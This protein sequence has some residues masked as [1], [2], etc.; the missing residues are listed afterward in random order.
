[1]CFLQAIEA[2]VDLALVDRSGD[3]HRKL[4]ASEHAVVGAGP[5]AA[6]PVYREV[7][8]VV[9]PTDVELA[10]LRRV[11]APIPWKVYTIAFVE[12]VERMSFY[13]TTAVFNNFIQ[14]PN[15]GTRTGAAPNPNDPEAQPGALNLGQRVAQAITLTN[16]MMVYFFPLLGAWVADTYLGRFKTIVYAIIIAEIGHVLLT[17]SAAPGMLE[18]PPQALGLFIIGLVIM[19][20]GTG[21][22]KPN[23]SPLIAEQ[24]GQ[25]VM[26]VQVTKKGE[27]VIVDPNI[28][29]SR[30]FNWF[31]LFINVGSLVGSLGMSYA[32]R[33]VGFYLSFLIPT[34]MFLTTLP[35]LFFC[36]KYYTQRPPEGSV[37]GPAFKLLFLGMKKGFSPNPI[38][39]V[40]RWNNG[41]FWQNV[42]VTSKPAWM[43]FDDAWVDE[44]ARGWA[45]CSV[46]LFYPLYWLTYN[47]MNNNLGAQ[48]KTMMLHGVPNDVM[49]NLNPIA[50]IVFVPLMDLGFYPLL[51]RFGI[52]F[53]PIKKITVGFFFSV[54]AMIWAAVLQHYIYKMSPCGKQASAKCKA[55]I[56]VW[57]QTGI[58]VLVAISEIFAS[59]TSLEYAYTKAPKNMRSLVQAFSLM[60][61]AFSAALGFALLGLADNPFLVWNYAIPGFIAFAA[62]CV[63]W[64]MYRGLDKREDHLNLLP[65]GHLVTPAHAADVE[66]RSGRS[67]D[68][69][70][71]K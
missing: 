31:Y 9:V 37:L 53:T 52:R 39:T 1:M 43:T 33:Y 5:E 8:G 67:V 19:A 51:R 25:S 54:M 57:A 42:K 36:K 70:S 61:N 65:T 60:T 28:T 23:I 46:F 63:F 22:F 26:Q 71:W 6:P 48:A 41:T 62:M 38:A 44:V 14:D 50:I 10:T 68:K 34:L 16:S 56:N 59:I 13:G 64:L 11:P 4:P 2:K 27:R 12:L 69:S 29:V 24:I 21:G 7:E 18:K 47:Q 58:Y 15:P 40:R 30:I 20:V 32:E 66:L 35:V 3:P 17:A 45:A 49:S 55:P